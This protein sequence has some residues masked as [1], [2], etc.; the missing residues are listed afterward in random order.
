MAR[1][2]A[3]RAQAHPAPRP[4]RLLGRGG[5]RRPA[6]L[7]RLGVGLALRLGLGPLDVLH[8]RL[9]ETQR[10]RV[11]TLRCFVVMVIARDDPDARDAF[12]DLRVVGARNGRPPKFQRLGKVYLSLAVF[13]QVAKGRGEA[14]TE[15]ANAENPLPPNRLLVGIDFVFSVFHQLNRS[16]ADPFSH[17]VHDKLVQRLKPDA[18]SNHLKYHFLVFWISRLS[19]LCVD[20]RKE[21]EHEA[22]LLNE[23]V[24]E[25]DAVLRAERKHEVFVQLRR[26][27]DL[28]QTPHP[29][30]RQGLGE[31]LSKKHR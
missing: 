19:L 14:E 21:R 9:G 28:V 13:A 30:K 23:H 3:P 29:L 25:L 16:R 26:G 6:L 1:D 31:R 20:V 12:N 27:H 4:P 22:R 15:R 18:I 2:S 8:Q 17:L 7:C 10:L 11:G 24:L 5:G